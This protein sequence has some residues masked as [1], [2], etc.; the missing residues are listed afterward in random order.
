MEGFVEA[1]ANGG[2]DGPALTG[3]AAAS[4]VPLPRKI[5]IPTPFF[6]DIGRY[7]DIWMA[8]RI[9]TIG[10]A[11]GTLTLD[12]RFGSTVA[13]NGGASPTLIVSQTNLTWTASI[14]L[15]A[16]AVGASATMKGVGE[17]K[18][19]GL[20]TNNIIMLPSTAIANGN[21]FDATAPQA[22]DVFGTFS[23]TGNSLT[24]HGFNVSWPTR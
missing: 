5:T 10:S 21:T 15:W 6:T 13:W 23:V 7:V 9:S 8:G 22:L 2:E 19:P 20:V 3:T 24:V 17:I 14:R 18:C 1:V 11:P 4:I 16:S 12:V